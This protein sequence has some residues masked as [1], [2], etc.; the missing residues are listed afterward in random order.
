MSDKQKK[1]MYLHVLSSLTACIRAVVDENEFSEKHFQEYVVG[2]NEVA[3]RLL[4]R[5]IDLVTESNIW[6]DKKIELI[7][8]D[9]V[10]SY[11]CVSSCINS[12]LDNAQLIS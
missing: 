12:A 10:E 8:D 2:I 1:I 5:V 3:H 11:P 7:L 6:D 9:I 4:N